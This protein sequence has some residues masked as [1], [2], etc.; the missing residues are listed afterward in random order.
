MSKYGYRET[1]MSEEIREKEKEDTWAEIRKAVESLQ[2]GSVS[3]TVHDGKI[4]QVETS[5]KVRFH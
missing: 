2:F 1:R 3:I 5:T 4:V